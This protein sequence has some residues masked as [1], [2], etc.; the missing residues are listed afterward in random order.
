[1][2]ISVILSENVPE[3]GKRGEEIQVRR[4]FARNYLI[5]SKKAVYNTETNKALFDKEKIIAGQGDGNQLLDSTTQKIVDVVS[6]S[7]VTIER[8]ND[9]R[10]WALY[11]QHISM[12]CRKQLQLHVPLDRIQLGRPLISFG[13]HD[14]VIRVRC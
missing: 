14:V 11:P 13:V 7:V 9:P 10:G 6:Q 4:G 12:A 5:P 3:L 8:R 1:V 2:K